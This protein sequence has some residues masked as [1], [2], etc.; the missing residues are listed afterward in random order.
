MSLFLPPELGLPAGIMFPYAGASVPSGYLLCDGS[1]VSRTAY[2]ALFAALGVAWGI[3]DGLTTFNLPDMRQRM[4]LGKSPLGTGSVLGSYGGN[5]DHTHTTPNHTH[6]LDNHVHSVGAHQHEL[7][8]AATNVP[9]RLLELVENFPP[10]VPWAP[11]FGESSNPFPA[12]SF[13]EPVELGTVFPPSSPP[14]SNAILS[15]VASGD[16]GAAAGNTG[17]GGGAISSTNNPPFG[18]VNFI[19]KT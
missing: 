4:P 15:N 1:A 14:S 7:P 18:V 6:S 19:I 12:G 17:L 5:I 13:G 10:P 16:T 9:S 8:F 3:G 2:A 11:I